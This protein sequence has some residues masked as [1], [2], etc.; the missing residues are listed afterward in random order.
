MRL[1]HAVAPHPSRCHVVAPPNLHTVPIMRRTS[2]LWAAAAILLGACTGGRP[3]TEDYLTVVREVVSVMEKDARTQA[4]GR[5]PR[6]PLWV[7]ARGFAGRAAE[8]TGVRITKEQVLAVL[9]PDVRESTPQQV[10]LA[11]SDEDVL[12]GTW[13]REY[14]VHVS[15]NAARGTRDQITILV[16]NYSTDRRAMPT[17]ICERLWRM[18][19]RRQPDG[20]WTATERKLTRPCVAEENP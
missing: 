17:D 7:D 19:F 18:R 9:G 2:P 3:T 16:A 11:S 14:G 4:L 6:G 13:V 15:P 5:P 1:R 8:V 20:R 10:L 12:G